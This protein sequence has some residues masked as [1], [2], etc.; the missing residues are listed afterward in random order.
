MIL[1]VHILT[2]LVSVVVST[3]LLLAPSET[4]LKVSYGLIAG[5]F[6]S[7]T[8][9]I[10]SAGSHLLETCLMGLAYS[11]FTVVATI[12][13]SRKMAVAKERTER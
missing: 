1:V 6:A 4:R 10:I 2:A 3:S 5:T 7:G 8:I 12:V 13:A 9:L 11:A